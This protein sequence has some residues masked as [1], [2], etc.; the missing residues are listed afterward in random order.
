[1]KLGQIA[2]ISSG[3][4]VARKKAEL[5]PSIKYSILTL[6]SFAEDGWIDNEE[7]EEF[8]SIEALSSQHLTQQGD[9]IVR[10]SYPHTAVTITGGLEGLL[11]PSLFAVIRLNTDTI[12]PE[13]LSMYLNSEIARKQLVK[14][15][16][17]TA[18]TIIRTGSLKELEVKEIPINEQIKLVNIMMLHIKEKMLLNNLLQEKERLFKAVLKKIL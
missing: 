9:V 1:M 14:D 13:Y 11:I 17:G 4:V 5:K 12:L 8:E 6:K 15:S 3:L 7:L 18:L 2:N 10:L 16:F